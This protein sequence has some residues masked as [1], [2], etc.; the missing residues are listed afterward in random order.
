MVLIEVKE[1]RDVG[2]H[3]IA[4]SVSSLVILLECLVDDVVADFVV[5]PGKYRVRTCPTMVSY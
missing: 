4:D 3:L 2:K 1:G 5:F